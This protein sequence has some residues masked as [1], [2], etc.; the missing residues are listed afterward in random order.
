FASDEHAYRVEAGCPNYLFETLAGIFYGFP[1][2]DDWGIKVARHTGGD[3]VTDPLHVDREIDPADLSM[4]QQFLTAHLP[5]VEPR[6]L[7]HSVCMYT[8]T[9]DEHFL[10]DRHPQ[11]RQVAFVAG[12]SGHGFKFTPVLGEVLAD[13]T[14]TGRTDLPVGFLNCQRPALRS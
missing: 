10:V 5:G 8:M 4:V 14:T 3:V 11:H 12:L 2:I 13:L 6:L 9:P 1:Q 7:H